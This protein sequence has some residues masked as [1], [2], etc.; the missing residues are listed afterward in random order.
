M[1]S[2]ASGRWEMGACEKGEMGK[3]SVQDALFPASEAEGNIVSIT[4][5]GRHRP[6]APWAFGFFG[7]MSIFDT[8]SY[9]TGKKP[10]PPLIRKN[11]SL[12]Q[13]FAKALT[14][15]RPSSVP[16]EYRPGQALGPP[17][18]P[19]KIKTPTHHALLREKNRPRATG[20]YA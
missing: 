1:R 14:G 12:A 7:V 19:T 16:A 2:S 3:V 20:V 5:R 11:H 15:S 18:L 10:K 9:H 4:R 13:I 8:T 17:S 6:R